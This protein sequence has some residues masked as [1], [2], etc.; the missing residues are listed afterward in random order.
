MFSRSHLLP[1]QLT[2]WMQPGA[3]DFMNAASASILTLTALTYYGAE[4]RHG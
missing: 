4:A 3:A 2:V 1:L